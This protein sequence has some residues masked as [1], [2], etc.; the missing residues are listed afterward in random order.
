MAKLPSP[1]STFEIQNSSGSAV[2]SFDS[3]GNASFSG[4]LTAQNGQFNNLT[5]EQLNNVGDASISG[6][7]RASRIVADQI[8]LSEEGLLSLLGL[9]PQSSTSA[10]IFASNPFAYNPNSS[11]SATSYPQQLSNLT[12]EQLTVNSGLLSFGPASFFEASVADR[13]F[14]GSQL[15]LADKSINVLG[16]NLELQPLKQGGIAFVGGE[17]EIDTQGNLKVNGNAYFA[18][19]VEVNGKLAA[20]IISPLADQDLVVELGS[21]NQESGSEQNHDSSFIIRDSS[22]SGVLSINSRGDLSASGSGTF[23]KLNLSIVNEALA[24]SPTEVIATG[25]A[26]TANIAPNKTELTIINPL[27]TKDSLIYITPRTATPNQSVYLLRQVPHESFT[28]G[29]SQPV[30]KKVPFNWIIIN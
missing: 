18:K 19:D 3:E 22:Q 27:V 12:I 14:V 4:K 7:L 28:V 21:T 20:N 8:E 6:T 30:N 16:G 9:E 24:V 1:D 26:G 10:T 15:S 29:I 2:S 25:S 13:L 17:V 5:I 23:N 11:S